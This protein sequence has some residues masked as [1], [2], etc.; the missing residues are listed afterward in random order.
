MKPV[1]I[2]TPDLDLLGEIDNYES[3]MFARSFHSIGDLELRVN[4]YKKYA[5]TLQKGNIILVGGQLHKVYKILHREIELDQNGK[6]TEN[7]LIKALELKVV[8]GQRITLPPSHTAYDNKSGDA[9]TV[10]KHYVNSN[11][12]DPVDA[13]RKIVQL[14]LSANQN[15]GASVSWQSR[16]K[17]LAE[18]LVS[19]SLN[20]GLGWNVYLDVQKKKWVFDVVEGRDVTAGQ[21]ILPPVIFSPTFDNIQSMSFVDSDLNYK[22]TAYVAGQGE[23]IERRVIEL[24]QSTGLSRHELFVDARDVAEETEGETPQPRPE[25]DIIADLTNRGEQNLKEMETELF[26]EAQIMTPI[27]R[28]EYERSYSYVSPY[29][30]N[31]EVKRKTKVYSAFMYEQ[32]FDL[33]D[34][35]TIQNKDW[36]VT[37]NT[38]ITE[39]KEIYEASGFSLEATFGNNRPTL[40]QKIKQELSQ[41]SGEVRR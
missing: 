39:I 36:G 11:I 2:L 10:M 19:I 8:T 27:Q 4:R 5:D 29:Q 3:L 21:T 24:G 31:E 26:L 16:F 30:V 17:N 15:R 22:N 32:D 20:S 7:W 37:V 33:G 14:I 13:N 23:G 41:I 1:R 28:S 12:I 6:I 35:V 9:E 18:E 40:I 38:R 34:I 25:A